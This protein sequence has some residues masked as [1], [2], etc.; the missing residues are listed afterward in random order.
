MSTMIDYLINTLIIT[1]ITAMINKFIDKPITFESIVTIIMM[2]LIMTIVFNYSYF[3]KKVM[4]LFDYVI[5]YRIIEMIPDIPDQKITITI[6]GEQ[7]EVNSYKFF[8]R[9]CEITIGYFPHVATS[10]YVKA[11]KRII[12]TANPNNSWF[13]IFIAPIKV[14]HHFEN[15]NFNPLFIKYNKYFH[16]TVLLDV[17][18]EIGNPIK[19][20]SHEYFNYDIALSG[21]YM[22][23]PDTSL[24][25]FSVLCDNTYQCKNYKKVLKI[26]DNYMEFVQKTKSSASCTILLNGSPGLGKSRITHYIGIHKPNIEILKIN[27]LEFSSISIGKLHNMIENRKMSD[28][29]IKV[30]IFDEIDKYM[31]ISTRTFDADINDVDVDTKSPKKSVVVNVTI[32]DIQNSKKKKFLA[33]L[34]N[35]IDSERLSRTIFMFCT[36]NI[37]DIF[38]G[39]EKQFL[40]LKTRFKQIVFEEYDYEDIVGF[41]GFYNQMYKEN[42]CKFYVDEHTF[43]K[44]I[45]Q[46]NKDIKLPVRLLTQIMI[47]SNYEIVETLDQLIDKGNVA[48][49]KETYFDIGKLN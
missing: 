14:L 37:L 42:E 11:H 48:K 3:L 29:I 36:N 44:K 4:K 20:L 33:E 41:L 17:I 10:N 31:E 49:L 40:S 19:K 35:M 34:Q 5:G 22:N 26:I 8:K 16:K 25:C 28:K 46:I 24:S 32:E 1:N 39:N 23:K 45:R 43:N 21:D 12:R 18:K 13:P 6:N 38:N 27:M 47:N 15:S 9:F 7:Y 30:I 2:L